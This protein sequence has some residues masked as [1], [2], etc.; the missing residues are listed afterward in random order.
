MP[1]YVSFFL[2]LVYNIVIKI[3]DCIQNCRVNKKNDL[4]YVNNKILLCDNWFKRKT[5]KD[6]YKHNIN[7]NINKYV[8]GNSYKSCY[9]KNNNVIYF[10]KDNAIFVSLLNAP[11]V[12]VK[13]NDDKYNADVI[14]HNVKDNEE[15]KKNIKD[16]IKNVN[17]EN[18]NN[19]YNIYN[20]YNNI[21]H[22][23]N[24]NSVCNHFNFM[25]P[26]VKEEEPFS[27]FT[28]LNNYSLL[29]G[30]KNNFFYKDRN[31]LN[32]WL[33]TQ[34]LPPNISYRYI[35]NIVSTFRLCDY[36]IKENIL[37][38]LLLK[39]I[40][41]NKNDNISFEKK[42]ELLNIIDQNKYKFI[43]DHARVLHKVVK[44]EKDKI[45][46]HI[47]NEKN[48]DININDKI[49]DERNILPIYNT[50]KNKNNNNNKNLYD[51]INYNNKIIDI[52]LKMRKKYNILF[53][54]LKRE[55]KQNVYKIYKKIKRNITFYDFY[56]RLLIL[57]YF[58]ISHEHRLVLLFFK[59]YIYK[60]LNKENM[61]IINFIN[62][63]FQNNILSKYILYPKST[64]NESIY[65]DIKTNENISEYIKDKYKL[66]YLPINT[67]NFIEY[68]MKNF[69]FPSYLLSNINNN[70]YNNNKIY[71]HTYDTKFLF[72]LNML[73]SFLEMNNYYFIHKF[74]EQFCIYYSKNISNNIIY[75]DNK[76][77]FFILTL[78]FLMRYVYMKRKFHI[79]NLKDYEHNVNIYYE[80]ESDEY[81]MKDIKNIK[82]IQNNNIKK[83]NEKEYIIH[84]KND[85]YLSY[86]I[87]IYNED[88]FNYEQNCG[89]TNYY[90]DLNHHIIDYIKNVI[91]RGDI[92]NK[93]KSIYKNISLL[94]FLQYVF[95]LNLD[96]DNI[97]FLNK[98]SKNYFENIYVVGNTHEKNSQYNKNEKC[99]KRV[100]WNFEGIKKKEN[101]NNH[102]SDNN[103]NNNNDHNN[104][105]NNVIENNNCVNKKC[106]TYNRPSIFYTHDKYM[107]KDT[108]LHSNN[109]FL[110][111]FL[112]KG[113]KNILKSC[114]LKTSSISDNMMIYNYIFEQLFYFIKTYLNDN[115]N[116]YYFLYNNKNKENELILNIKPILSLFKINILFFFKL[117]YILDICNYKY[118]ALSIINKF[119]KKKW[120]KIINN[121]VIKLLI[122][123]FKCKNNKNCK[124]KLYLFSL[125]FIE[126]NAISEY[127][128]IYNKYK[129]IINSNDKKF[130]KKIFNSL[131]QKDNKIKN[132]NNMNNNNNINNNDIYYNNYCDGSTN[133]SF[134]IFKKYTLPLNIKQIFFLFNHLQKFN[135]N[136]EIIILYNRLFKYNKYI[137]KNIYLDKDTEIFTRQKKYVKS[138][139]HIYRRIFSIYINS[140]LSINNLLL[141]NDQEEIIK[142][143][144]NKIKIKNI[145]CP[146]TYSILYKNPL[147]IFLHFIKK[148]RN[149]K[150]QMS[151][152]RCDNTYCDN[153][154]DD[155]NVNPLHNNKYVEDIKHMNIIK[156]EVDMK[157]VNNIKKKEDTINSVNHHHINIKKSIEDI[158]R[159]NDLFSSLDEET[160]QKFKKSNLMNKFFNNSF[161]PTYKLL[162]K[163]DYTLIF[164]IIM[165]YI[166]KHKIIHT[167][168]ILCTDKENNL[169]VKGRGQKNK[170]INK[171][172]NNIL[173][174]YLYFLLA[175]KCYTNIYKIDQI[176]FLIILK[177]FIIMDDMTS[178][179]NFLLI[180]ENK[181]L[182]DDNI[183]YINS[184]INNYYVDNYKNNMKGLNE[185]DNNIIFPIKKGICID[186]YIMKDNNLIIYNLNY[187]K[188]IKKFCN[189]FKYN[190]ILKIYFYF[191][192][193]KISHTLLNL[194]SIF[195]HL[196]FLNNPQFIKYIYDKEGILLSLKNIYESSQFVIFYGN[197]MFKKSKIFEFLTSSFFKN[198]SIHKNDL[199]KDAYVFSIRGE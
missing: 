111:P 63:F 74:I 199:I 119:K 2:L 29:K 162:S 106:K 158:I 124:N 56:D 171:Y 184:L 20:I 13:I 43:L 176:T 96:I 170:K 137:K 134:K 150:L 69:F 110:F 155:K 42:I 149:K 70:K 44:K 174:I 104:N 105:N 144:K 147:Y 145:I 75:D 107:N 148:Y 54:T 165:K 14:E 17:K 178:F 135:L 40:Y 91:T 79:F 182:I 3:Y 185:K 26:Q 175:L 45:I 87:H 102:S 84:N 109:F 159:G 47:Y 127:M 92:Y 5:N 188:L 113:Y 46:K 71:V 181:K 50:E 21:Y 94:L 55:N 173:Y 65:T 31:K 168:D 53:V 66:Y 191:D 59:K 151:S 67:S 49:N 35:K 76:W 1:N 28:H 117:I 73:H 39:Y 10:N 157:N 23:Y 72:Y 166:Y 115:I 16:D 99:D 86:P 130:I 33:C 193:R 83:I 93:R 153:S 103:N 195:S 129:M 77:S 15:K 52:Y 125:S 12:G 64:Y 167:Y 154:S 126:N 196:K 38:H 41:Y 120:F 160:M 98:K 179:K 89:I 132:N 131:I 97:N 57:N 88:I 101:N 172:Y 19:I 100:N 85:N 51:N 136:Y 27:L 121:K 62:Y 164:Y 6:K 80:N 82:N 18:I 156:K 128:D 177:I 60:L 61:F 32:D 138:K 197:C 4:L 7:I 163:K 190:N 140:I 116:K 152:E 78:S 194:S 24:T 189:I 36:N 11:I 81:K 122:N 34:Y 187:Y 68:Y 112:I 118:I 22:I 30:K 37:Y 198:V 161:N 183:L 169:N 180:N 9:R 25:N 90:N 114:F 143:N 186:M 123:K 142:K 141:L 8:N 108:Y 95:L 146:S 58:H 133:K 48:K 139:S 192:C